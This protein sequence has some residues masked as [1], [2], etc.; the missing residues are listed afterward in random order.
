VRRLLTNVA[1]DLITVRFRQI[2]ACAVAL[3]AVG[4]LAGCQTKAGAAAVV[5]G[6]RISESDVNRYIDVGFVQPS[7]SSSAQQTQAPRVIVLNTLI[8]ARLMSTLLESLHALPSDGE[9]RKL[10]DEAFAVQL[11]AQQ[12]G[13]QADDLLRSALTK[14]GLEASFADVFVQ[15]LELK[16]AVIDKIK[17]QKQSDIADAVAKLGVSVSVSGRY[18]DWSAAQA[19]LV[20]YTPPAGVQLGTPTPSSSAPAPG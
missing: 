9:L 12:T 6:H 14:S 3:L 17:A 8:E 2:G 11:G 20:G 7:P 15:G 16:Q 18:G 13:T 19:S 1:G 10:H 5:G 4:G